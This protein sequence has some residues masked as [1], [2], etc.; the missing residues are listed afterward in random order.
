MPRRAL[1]RSAGRFSLV[2]ALDDSSAP[3]QDL[4]AAARAVA[5]SSL[6]ALEAAR[7]ANAEAFSR[8]TTDL[9]ACEPERVRLVLG[10]VVRDLL[11]RLHPDG[12]SAEDLQAAIRDCVRRSAGWYPDIDVQALVVVITGALGMHGDEDQPR[13][14]PID[15][16]RHA[17][18]FIAE[19][20]S[21]PNPATLSAAD[22]LRAG[23]DRIRTAELHDLP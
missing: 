17:P 1:V 10:E 8:A 6:A 3:L 18:L 2:S 4:P 15:M 21:R 19:L 11:E 7:A 14:S 5:Q 9:A 12:L 22:H 23:F 20:L 13:Y 16:A